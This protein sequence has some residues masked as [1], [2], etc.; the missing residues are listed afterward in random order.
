MGSALGSIPEEKGES[1]WY[2]SDDEED[3][4]VDFIKEDEVLGAAYFIFKQSLLSLDAIVDVE[5]K[6]D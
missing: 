5:L 4:E 6:R 2:E 1:G 3:K